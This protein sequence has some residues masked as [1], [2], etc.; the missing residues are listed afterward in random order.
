MGLPL[1]E[2][3]DESA[4]L[5]ASSVGADACVV[6]EHLAGTGQLLVRGESGTGKLWA[7]DGI[8]PIDAEI[9]FARLLAPIPDG[10]GAEQPALMAPQLLDLGVSPSRFAEMA[11]RRKFAWGVVARVALGREAWGVVAVFTPTDRKPGA[12]ELE[13]LE[14]AAALLGAAVVQARSRDDV[15]RSQLSARVAAVDRMVAVSTLAAGAAHEIN[16]PL[17]YVAANAEFV[18]RKLVVLRE[19]LGDATVDLRG[20]VVDLAD[21]VRACAECGEGVERVRDIVDKLRSMSRSDGAARRAVRVDQLMESSLRM[22]HNE[23]R[24]RAKVSVRIGQL[25]PVHGNETRLTQVFLN[26]LLNAAQSIREGAAGE[27]EIA[28]KGFVDDG[29]VVIEVKDTGCGIAPADQPRIWDPFFTTKPIGTGSGLGLFVCRA[30]VEA[31][32]GRVLLVESRPNGGT[33][34]RI[35]LPPMSAPETPPEPPPP[36]P[37]PA[38]RRGRILVIDDE[39]LIGKTL[40]RALG[41]ENDVVAVTSGADALALIDRGERFDVVFCDLMMPEMSGMDFYVALGGREPRLLDDVVFMTGGAFTSAAEEFLRQIP[42]PHFEKP[43]QV[44]R[45]RAFVRDHLRA[46]ERGA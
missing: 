22:V 34:M 17:A 40:S 41:D 43:F 1:A 4:R 10:A 31:H 21:M 6:L 8:I 5:V 3:L 32:G 29:M 44:E 30:T 33:T 38:S 16:N 7:R 13:T 2:M 36:D 18:R 26:L 12:A 27:H 9:A 25:P 20:D 39:P 15:T 35:E 28:I 19:T 14:L 11:R 24:H 46:G 45:L 37:T 42:N 23:I